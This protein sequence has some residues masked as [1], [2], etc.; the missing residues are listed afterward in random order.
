MMR[1]Y[2]SILHP[3]RN[4]QENAARR[5]VAL[6]ILFDRGWALRYFRNNSRWDECKNSSKVHPRSFGH[7]RRRKEAATSRRPSQKRAI[8]RRIH[9][10]PKVAF[11]WRH[12]IMLALYC[13]AASNRDRITLD[14][15]VGFAWNWMKLNDIEWHVMKFNEIQWTGIKLHWNFSPERGSS[16]SRVFSREVYLGLE[17]SLQW[18][19]YLGL[20][21][22]FPWEVYLG[23]EFS[24][25]RGLSWSRA[26]SDER[27]ILVSSFLSDA[28]K[29]RK[30][31]VIAW[32]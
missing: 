10:M 18:E 20:E 12:R 8:R 23:L 19:V 31:N 28:R 21:F 26:L 30:L 17:L 1:G 11:Y 3:P 24:P 6:C 29:Y 5:R 22:S 14:A 4:L 7:K 9:P 16:W 25:M 2:K 32:N 27:F 13:D 15:R